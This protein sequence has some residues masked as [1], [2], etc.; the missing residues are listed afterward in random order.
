MHSISQ[1]SAHKYSNMD[2][3]HLS[4]L[5]AM[6]SKNSLDQE[7]VDNKTEKRFFQG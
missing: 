1:S 5:N 7:A 6:I 3:T 2:R 4:Y